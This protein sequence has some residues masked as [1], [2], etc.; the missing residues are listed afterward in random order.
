MTRVLRWSLLLGVVLMSVTTTQAA[1]QDSYEGKTV[2]IIAAAPPGGGFDAYARL[3]ARHMG[4]HLP[5]NP[6]TIVVNIPGGSGV[7]AANYMYNIAK[8]DGATIAH[9]SW[10]IAQMD[11]LGATGVQYDVNKFKWLGLANTSPITAAIRSGSPIQ[12]EKQWLDPKTPPLIFGCTT[13]SSLTCSLPLALNEIFGPI[14][15]VVPGYQ[16]TAPVRAGLLQGE[17]DGLTGWSWDSV[18]ATGKGMLDE[19]AIKLI[20]YIGERPNKE[21]DDLKVPYLTPKITKPEDKAFM[22]IL[23]MP[24]AMLRPWLAPPNTSKEKVALLRK[25]F[26]ETVKD[27]KFL[28]DAKRSRIEVN[29]ESGEWLAAFIKSM[30]GELTPEVRNRARKIIGLEQ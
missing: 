21:L 1:S 28:K 30:K 11:Y 3:F 12:T 26:N 22:K 14:S 2:K 5:G 27:P 6:K 8:P 15:K 25:A 9:A 24:A 7:I 17:V 20:A 16:G 4:K 29:P 18:K 13:R 19:G 23:L 10:G